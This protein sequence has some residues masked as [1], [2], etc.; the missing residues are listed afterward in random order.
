MSDSKETIQARL[1]SNISDE[2]DKSEGSFF[3]DAEMPVA[4]E[5]ETAYKTMNGI[6]DKGFADTAT[7]EYLEKICSEFGLTTSEG[8]VRK[9][10]KKATTT[11]LVVG[12]VGTV[13]NIG[14]LV[15]SDSLNY[16]F[17]ENKTIDST[18]KTNINVECT[19][20]GAI[21]NV[22]VGV[23]KYFPITIP[24]LTAVTN[25]TAVANGYDAETDS[26]LRIRFY[27]KVRTPATS[28]N[29]YHYRNWAKEVA[30]VGDA[31]VFPLWNGN[32]TVKVTIIN[33]NRRAADNT[34]VTSVASYI[35]DN[36]PIGATVTVT[37]ATEKTI[38]IIVSLT[39][40]TKNYT[41][42]AVKTTI[43]S[44]LTEYFKNIAFS[45]TVKYISYA[46]IGAIIF[47]TKGVLDYSNLTINNGTAN[48]ALADEEI[49]VLGGVTV[50]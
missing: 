43:I 36:R 11:V 14:G 40:D 17:T 24:G 25:L 23:I 8:A 19:T 32:G 41:T 20:A 34:L 2:Y 47:N 13:I 15:A 27:E 33:S 12:T 10:A 29:K 9:Q 26:E 22:P 49:P 38:N 44:N 7:A 35:E 46:N 30:G 28:G 50:G 21:G 42:D 45:E 3:Y 37:S 31:R 39:I 4:I 16:A 5:L 6:L 1:L 18:G 48:I